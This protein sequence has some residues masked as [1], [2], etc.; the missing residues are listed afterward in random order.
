VLGTSFNIKAYPGNTSSMVT[1][2]TGSVSVVAKENNQLKQPPVVVKANERV[3][4]NTSTGRLSGVQ[5]CEAGNAIAWKEQRFVCEQV[6]LGDVLEDMSRIYH[7]TV[8]ADAVMR[9]C[10][11]SADFTNETPDAILAVLAELTNGRL[12]KQ[13][14]HF[15]LTGKGCLTGGKDSLY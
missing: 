5:V 4:H 2:L 1:V 11:I 15:R 6:R 8:E 13:G 3:I 10:V 14:N 9:D 12:I 7:I